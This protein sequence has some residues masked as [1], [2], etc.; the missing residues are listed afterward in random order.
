VSTMWEEFKMGTNRGIDSMNMNRSQ[1]LLA[2]GLASIIGLLIALA[3]ILP[4][5]SVSAVASTP[6]W[7]SRAALALCCCAPLRARPAA[8]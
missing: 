6:A 5:L 3:P 2:W 1:K 7:G 4:E 8:G